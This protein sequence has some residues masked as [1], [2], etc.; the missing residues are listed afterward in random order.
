MKKTLRNL[1]LSSLTGVALVAC[2]SFYR[3]NY[4]GVVNGH[5]VAISQ[6]IPENKR[7]MV[8]HQDQK[9]YAFDRVLIA[10]DSNNDGKFESI[11]SGRVSLETERMPID[12]SSTLSKYA[13]QDSLNSIYNALLEKVGEK[14]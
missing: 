1:A 14:K 3:E 13:N 8:I 11:Y 7:R 5:L 10:E 12:S 2:N 6:S 4:S 9:P